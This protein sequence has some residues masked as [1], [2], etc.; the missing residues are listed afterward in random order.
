MKIENIVFSVSGGI[1]LTAG[2]ISTCFGVRNLRQAR[3]SR[4]WNCVE[5][6]IVASEVCATQFV[7]AEVVVHRA[8]VRYRYCVE[9]KT[10]ES[11]RISFAD[12][13]AD[14]HLGEENATAIASLYPPG[15]TVSVFYSPDDPGVAVLAHDQGGGIYTM[16][17]VG[18]VS[19]LTGAGILAACW[20]LS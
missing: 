19:S 14:S 13:D 18:I 16:L 10:Y 15:R 12:E 4:S 3:Q 6:R 7:P 9:G 20:L 1:I 17:R 11:S 8:V 5:G 2:L